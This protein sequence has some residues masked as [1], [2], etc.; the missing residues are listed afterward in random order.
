MVNEPQ[1]HRSWWFSK[2][3]ANK[4]CQLWLRPNNRIIRDGEMCPTN[5]GITSLRKKDHCHRIGKKFDHRSILVQFMSFFSI[6]MFLVFL[7]TFF[8]AK[9][10][11]LSAISLSVTPAMKRTFSFDLFKLYWHWKFINL[12][13]RIN[14]GKQKGIRLYLFSLNWYNVT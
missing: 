5:I 12:W 6:F 1:K 7:V 9:P 14:Q 8:V 11:R 2:K 4:H 13:Q 3:I 10:S